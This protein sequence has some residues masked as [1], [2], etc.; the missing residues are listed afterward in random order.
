MLFLSASST[1]LRFVACECKMSKQKCIQIA[2]NPISFCIVCVR[3][4]CA[5]DRTFFS[6]SVYGLGRDEESD[7]CCAT[8][9]VRGPTCKQVESRSRDRHAERSIFEIRLTCCSPPAAHDSLIYKLPAKLQARPVDSVHLCGRLLHA[10]IFPQLRR[11]AS[12]SRRHLPAAIIGGGGRASAT[13]GKVIVLAS[14]ARCPIS[15]CLLP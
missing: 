13:S 8:F 5:Y 11:P 2:R 6:S 12:S 14:R 1:A 10:P 4:E 7:Y 3:S 15:V 9:S